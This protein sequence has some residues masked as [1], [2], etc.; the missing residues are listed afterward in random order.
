MA[1]KILVFG[2]LADITGWR[3]VNRNKT[4]TVASFCNSLEEQFPGLK[5]LHYAVAVNNK[6]ATKETLLND[7]DVLALLPPFSGG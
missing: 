1:V 3:E 5:G 2:K 6:S 4:G 7:N